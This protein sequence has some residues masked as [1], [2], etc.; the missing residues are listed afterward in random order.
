MA[1]GSGGAVYDGRKGVAI[2][3]GNIA[4]G[5]GSWLVTFSSTYRKPR[6]NRK[7]SIPM[8]SQS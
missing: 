8:K 6:E 7:W 5:T 1:Y 3:R 4:S 2:V